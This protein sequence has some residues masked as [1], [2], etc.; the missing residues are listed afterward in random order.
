MSDAP[1]YPDTDGKSLDDQVRELKDYIINLHRYIRY[2][3]NNIDV[4]N[5][6]L[7]TAA[8]VRKVG[9]ID[10]SVSEI[11]QDVDRISLS[12]TT[13]DGKVSLALNG[14]GGGGGTIDLTGMVTFENLAASDGKTI[15][16]ADNITTGIING[17][18]FWSEN[19]DSLGN[20]TGA[21]GMD[22]GGIWFF[23]GDNFDVDVSRAR[24]RIENDTL[25]FTSGDVMSDLLID[26][27]GSVSI[28]GSPIKLNGAEPF[29]KSSVI[30]IANGGTGATT[31]R[32]AANNF[33]ETGT[34]TPKLICTGTNAVNP[35][36]TL[37]NVVGYYCRIGKLV[38]I[39]CSMDTK[40]TAIGSGYAAVGGLPF[41][42]YDGSA[43]NLI[44][45]YNCITTSSNDIHP[46]VHLGVSGSTYYAIFRAPSGTGAYKWKVNSDGNIKISG[47]YR[48][49]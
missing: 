10:S 15:I 33:Y 39:Y 21:V 20:V 36:Y 5:M 34:W 31:V 40:I 19:K 22:G 35:T 47:V 32:D 44:Q 49:G 46:I 17:A 37:S 16:N 38:H 30:P 42:F 8:S 29:T 13:K 1:R 27:G 6:T 26:F 18:A 48:C 4:R 3:M 43:L 25:N 14:A 7:S 12:V 2:A 24:L 9:D 45:A 41:A 23:N 11:I 28:N